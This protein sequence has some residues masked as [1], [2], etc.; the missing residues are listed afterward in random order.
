VQ[1][2]GGHLWV[3]GCDLLLAICEGAVL[4]VMCACSCWRSATRADHTLK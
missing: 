3:E 2:P 4:L 1:A